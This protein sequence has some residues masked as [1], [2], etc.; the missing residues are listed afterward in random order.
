MINIDKSLLFQ[1]INFLV[2]V[3]I[4]YKFAFKPIT[5]AL[6]DRADGIKKS[7]DDA[8][9]ANEE[10]ERRLKEYSD[11]LTTAHKEGEVIRERA[12]QE[13]LTEGQRLVTDAKEEAGRLVEQAKKDIEGEVKKARQ[14]LREEV[15]N[16]SLQVT[17]KILEKKVDAEDH[18]RLVGEYIS[19]MGALH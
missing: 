13:A 5:K 9:A 11:K 14:E 8:K 12:R 19:K 1:V 7:L 18:K 16:I 3:A 2:L 4:L 17:E 15:V 6:Q 10:A